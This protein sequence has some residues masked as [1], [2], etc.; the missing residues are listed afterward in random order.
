MKISIL[1][2]LLTLSLFCVDFDEAVK[3]Y[4]K[5]SYIQALNIFYVLAKEG[6]PEAQ[7]NVGVIYANGKGVKADMTEA[8]EWY[9]KAATQGNGAA[10]YN[11]AQQYHTQENNNSHALSMA[12]KW[13]E[14]AVEKEVPQA[15]NNLAAM[16]LRGVG[17]KKNQKK[18]FVLF[19]KA[20]KL[21]DPYAQINIA[22]LYAWGAT[23]IRDKK[24][25]YGLLLKARE[26]G[27][28][29]AQEYIDKL[30]KEKPEFCKK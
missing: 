14:V 26:S 22:K 3:N 29:E 21:G 6:D 2:V 10:A 19:S 1:F 13:Y 28:F 7:Y 27:K 12:V 30:C 15:Y 17:V 8:M 4:E 23:I 24:K 16:Y 11:L 25:A 9:E 18:A 20:V 5:G